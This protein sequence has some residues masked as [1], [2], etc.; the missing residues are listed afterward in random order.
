M[1]ESATYQEIQK[2]VQLEFGFKPKT[3]WIAHCKEIYGLPLGAAP[4]RQGEERVEPC[5][6]EKRP[7][8]KKAF[9]H[10]GMLS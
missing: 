8:I 9:Q 2:W 10:F 6:P 7:A 3:C 1:R 4:N 5:P